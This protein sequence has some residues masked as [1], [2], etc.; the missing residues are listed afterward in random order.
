MEEVK[1]TQIKSSIGTKPEHRKT[2]LAL[3]LRKI[4]SSRQHKK[5][6]QL[7]GMLRKVQFL[8]KVEK[9]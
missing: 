9:V 5:N 4:G 1:I 2:L 7:E 3:G 8:V 6:P